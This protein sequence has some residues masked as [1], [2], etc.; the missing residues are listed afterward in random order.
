[1]IYEA[2]PKD[3]GDYEVWRSIPG[4]KAPEELVATFHNYVRHLMLPSV[5]AHVNVAKINA[6]YFCE[7][8]NEREK[9]LHV[10]VERLHSI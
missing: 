8:Q 9:L 10:V 2:R 1:M 3:N 4:S 5:V 6:E 7:E